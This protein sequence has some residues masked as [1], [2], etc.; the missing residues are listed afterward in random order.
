MSGAF[1]AMFRRFPVLTSG[2]SVC[3]IFLGNFK[4]LYSAA[5]R[6]RVA[7]YLSCVHCRK[8]IQRLLDIRFPPSHPRPEDDVEAVISLKAALAVTGDAATGNIYN[9][10]IDMKL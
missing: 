3:V 5:V 8:Y 6:A 10:P 7:V 2:R 4:L 9:M 1:D